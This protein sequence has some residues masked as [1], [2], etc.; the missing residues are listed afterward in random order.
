[1]IKKFPRPLPTARGKGW[2]P[3]QMDEMVTKNTNIIIPFHP[4]K[5]KDDGHEITK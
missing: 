1:L 2:K 3:Y 4:E 5:R